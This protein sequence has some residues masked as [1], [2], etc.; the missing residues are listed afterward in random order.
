MSGNTFGTVFRLTTYGE[1]H[2]PALGGVVD[3]CPPGIP[4]SEADIQ[5]LTAVYQAMKPKDAARVFDGLDGRLLVDI[6][7]L[8]NP[9]KLADV[10][11][12]MTPEVA[13]RLTAELARPDG[14]VVPAA[15]EAALP[16]IQG[17]L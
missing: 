2:G 9:K 8:M 5:R 16:K 10:V 11:A 17:K 3:G 6:A 1:S 14:R 4:L 7:R 13:Q 15:G 12:K